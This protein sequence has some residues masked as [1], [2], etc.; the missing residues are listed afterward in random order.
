MKTVSALLFSMIISFNSFSLE[1]L[2]VKVSLLPAEQVMI[3][4]NSVN[5]ANSDSYTLEMSQDAIDFKS[6]AFVKSIGNS[7]S[8]IY[9]ITHS[10][11][12]SGTAYF[13]IRHID[14][15]GNITYSGIASLTK[16]ESE[17]QISIYPNPSTGETINLR[18]DSK[19]SNLNQTVKLIGRTGRVIYESSL[20]S[21]VFDHQFNLE[22][23]YYFVWLTQASG[24]VITKKIVVN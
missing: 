2:D 3:E 21:G 12:F 18:V 20:N 6:F 17:V 23:G 22:K 4:W 8:Q 5:E 1:L 9:K 11:S 10:L 13:R 19:D 15:D 7:T 16:Q 24:N 14:Y